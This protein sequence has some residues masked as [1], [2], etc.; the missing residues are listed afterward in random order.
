MSI[1]FN[2][3]GGSLARGRVLTTG[4]TTP[5]PPSR[6]WDAALA[7]RLAQH[8]EEAL[9]LL[10]DSCGRL[11]YGRALQIL[12]EPRLAEEVAQDTLLVLW[13]NP[14]RFDP[15]RGSIRAFLAAI[16]RY[17]SIDVA[18]RRD[19][20]RSRETLLSDWESFLGAP[21]A[22]HPQVENAM[23]LRDAMSGLPLAKREVIFLAFYRGL[24]YGQVAKVLDLPEGT[25]K[26]RIRDSLAWLK[27]ALA[28]GETI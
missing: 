27:A 19:L 22:D 24:T 7:L 20:V 4:D 2:R 15:A 17:K 11:V 10:I 23:V 16:A 1:L 28:T 25:V 14:G 5:L 18:R 8:D 13:W 21:S 9:R 3:V 12:Q 6:Q 26:S